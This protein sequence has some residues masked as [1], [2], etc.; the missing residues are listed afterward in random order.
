MLA[1]PT[2]PNNKPRIV[3]VDQPTG[4]YYV[5]GVSVDQKR[6]SAAVVPPFGSTLSS[7]GL[8]PA[9]DLSLTPPTGGTA[10]DISSYVLT[11]VKSDESGSNHIWLFEKLPGA[12]TTG[13]SVT[14]EGQIATITTQ[15]VAPGTTVTPSATVVDAKVTADGAGRS[16]KQIITVPSVFPARAL[17]KE[18]PDPIPPK[19]RT[20]IPTETS[21]ITEAGAVTSGTTVTLIGNE[22]AKTIEQVTEFVKRTSTTSR[23]SDISGTPS[24]V[25]KRTGM[26]GEETITESLDNDN[27]LSPGYGVKAHE[28]EAVAE[29]I[30]LKQKIDFPDTPATLIEYRTDEET[31]LTIKMEKSLVAANAD[32]P[33]GISPQKLVERQAIDKWHSIQIV[34][35]RATADALPSNETW[36]TTAN[37]SLPNYLQDAGIYW[38]SEKAESVGNGDGTGFFVGDP[39]ETTASATATAQLTMTVSGAAWVK[40]V[41]GYRGIANVEVTRSY[42]NT[43]PTATQ[44]IHIFKP[45]NGQIITRM[46]NTQ[47]NDSYDVVYRTD[48]VKSRSRRKSAGWNNRVQTLN[49]GPVEHNNFTTLNESGTKT[50]TGEAVATSTI[51]GQTG[52]TATASA[53]T[54]GSAQLILPASSTP[55]TSGQTFVLD[56]NVSKWRFG[57]WVTE[58]ITATVP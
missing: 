33:A 47:H 46:K 31:G 14:N 37:I 19:F 32:L 10:V 13:Y 39:A 2:F 44:S 40:I 36:K 52:A 20:L 25:S 35:T 48:G 50:M 4:G 18:I 49:F 8:L 15:P 34:S 57:I 51:G 54:L 38:E 22:I 29:D 21:R 28:A 53:T 16:V 45:V 55:L 11:Q 27:T 43:A 24:L 5:I 3:S 12:A 26:W 6:A 42:S 58:V 9:N 17:S 30:Y 23:D 1:Q 7:L 41:D 56:V